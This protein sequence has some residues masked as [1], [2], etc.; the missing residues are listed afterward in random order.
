MTDGIV[1]HAKQTSLMVHPCDS[2]YLSAA[3]PHNVGLQAWQWYGIEFVGTSNFFQGKPTVKLRHTF[4]HWSYLLKVLAGRSLTA[5]C[6]LDTVTTKL[7]LVGTTCPLAGGLVRHLWPFCC[8]EKSLCNEW[9]VCLCPALQKSCLFLNA[10]NLEAK[11]AKAAGSDV[12]RLFWWPRTSCFSKSRAF[13]ARILTWQ[14]MIQCTFFIGH[15][16]ASAF[17]KQ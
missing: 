16:G 8:V 2:S 11:Y 6:G 10:V 17:L 15:F 3:L 5:S 12:T 4:T 13:V 1:C 9:E 14:S 7:M